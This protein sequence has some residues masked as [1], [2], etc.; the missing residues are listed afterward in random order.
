LKGD[1]LVWTMHNYHDHET[2]NKIID[3]LSLKFLVKM[4]NAIIVHTQAGKDYLKNKYG[5]ENGIHII[6]MGHYINFY[7]QRLDRPDNGLSEKFNIKDG[8]KVF[9][10]L[11]SIRP[12]KGIEELIDVFND[13]PDNFKL[14][15][16]GRP[17]FED[18]FNGLKS[19]AKRD[20]IIFY[21]ELIPGDELPKFFS[22][23]S[24]SLFN[25]KKVLSSA[26]VVASLSYGVPIITP[27][28]GDL[29]YIALDGINGF[30]FD[31]I[32]QLKNVI[33]NASNID[34]NSWKKMSLD[35]ICGVEKNNY[36]DLANKT[37]ITYIK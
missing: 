36:I 6:S 2:K 27:S 21:G 25:F 3:S 24:F 7:G 14:I 32:G 16:A 34:S 31:D 9:L 35:C 22:L 33:I 17:F 12:Y 18:H 1:R 29:K 8:D 23:V 11:G 26:S 28:V 37:L 10:S 15:V 19:R 5:R 20:N 13:L 30:V 4:S